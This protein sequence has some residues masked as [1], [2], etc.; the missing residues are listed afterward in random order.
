MWLKWAGSVWLICWQ[1]QDV[2]SCVGW[3]WN[4]HCCC[5]YFCCLLMDTQGYVSGARQVHW[6]L[7]RNSWKRMHDTMCI[8]KVSASL[9]SSFHLP[10]RVSG[11]WVTSSLAMHKPT[12]VDVCVCVCVGAWLCICLEGR[13][14]KAVYW[15]QWKNLQAHIHLYI[16]RSICYED[17]T[18]VGN[19]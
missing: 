17:A 5:C 2:L 18:F 3:W 4:P 9:V 10:R 6:T 16:D 14:R 1:C 15:Q 7:K 11:E 19:N 12:D 13:R 8:S